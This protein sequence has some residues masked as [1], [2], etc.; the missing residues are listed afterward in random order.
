MGLNDY[1]R[2]N[3]EKESTKYY[4]I[5]IPEDYQKISF[6]LYSPYGKAKIKYNEDSWELIPTNSF[7]R[8]IIDCK[9]EKIKKDTLKGASF[10]I[11]ITTKE[12]LPEEANKDL[13]YYYLEVQGLYN[14][15]KAYYD[16]TNGRSIICNTEND[17]YCHVLLYL[18]H[19]Y[20]NQGNFVYALS[21]SQDIQILAEYYPSEEIESNSFKDSIQ[22]KFPK[23][24]DKNSSSNAEAFKLLDSSKISEK[25]DTYVLLTLD[26]GK[27]IV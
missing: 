2:G 24:T 16:L 3:L 15:E 1:V 21:N 13:F 12:N 25:K 5:L 6:N 19:Y 18:N 9:D 14:N 26:A 7:G 10:T 27:K 20:S 23:I 8:I 11:A 17:N 22:N 4:N